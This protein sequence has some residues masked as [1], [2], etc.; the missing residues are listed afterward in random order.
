MR[1]KEHL[2]LC[3]IKIDREPIGPKTLALVDFL[4][5]G[6]T[7]PPIHVMLEAGVY[8]IRDGR[9]RCLAYKLLGR[10][11][12]EARYGVSSDDVVNDLLPT[13]CPKCGH[14]W[15]RYEDDCDCG[16]VFNTGS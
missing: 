1:R 14:I 9:H 10:T 7:V 16:T 15:G 8:R 3:S 13:I 12:I 5:N 2:P 4:R 6:G 11:T